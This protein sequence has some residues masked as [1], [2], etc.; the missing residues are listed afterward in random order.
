MLIKAGDEDLVSRIDHHWYWMNEL[1][2]IERVLL[3]AKWA[4]MQLY[5]AEN[6]FD[7]MMIMFMLC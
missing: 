1:H 6:K 2:W 4:I 7:E 5:H 3:N